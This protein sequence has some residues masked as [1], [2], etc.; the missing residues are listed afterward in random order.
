MLAFL[1]GRARAPT[2]R[3]A[4]FLLDEVLEFR[5]FESFPGL[6][7][8]LPE[9]LAVAR[10]DAQPLRA[11]LALRHAGRARARD[12]VAAVRRRRRCR[13]LAD[14]ELSR[15]LAAAPPGARRRAVRRPRRRRRTP[16]AAGAAA[17]AQAGRPAVRCARARRW[18][19]GAAASPGTRWPRSPRAARAG[20]PPL[21][22]LRLHA[23]SCGCTAPAATARSRP[24]SRSC[25]RQ[26]PL[27]LTEISQRLGRTPGSTKDYL[28]W[29][30]D[31]DLVSVHRKRYRFRDP[32]LRV[33]VRLHCRPQDA[34][35][36]GDR[37]ARWQVRRSR[38]DGVPENGEPRTQNQPMRGRHEAVE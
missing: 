11:H 16:R 33:W 31:V 10:L 34:D 36:G 21:V 37:T 18:P 38:C 8:A 28:S 12:R 24:S 15:M 2:A 30:E 9:L 3:P 26:E 23:T 32:L 5:T 13:R 4:T 25:A 27:T 17:S 29:L 1:V 7:R 20:R 35:G 19:A 22:A 6:R 14:A